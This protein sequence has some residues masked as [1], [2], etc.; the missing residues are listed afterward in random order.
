MESTYERDEGDYGEHERMAAE[1]EELAGQGL[2]E[3]ELVGLEET[4]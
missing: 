3:G 4:L 1:L 2:D